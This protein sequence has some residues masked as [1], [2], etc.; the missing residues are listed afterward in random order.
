MGFCIF[1]FTIVMTV[2][3]KMRGPLLHEDDRRLAQEERRARNKAWAIGMRQPPRGCSYQ[4]WHRACRDTR[5]CLKVHTPEPS[6]ENP[7]EAA[8]VYLMID[9]DKKIKVGHSYNLPKRICN[10]QH[11]PIGGMPPIRLVKAIAHERAHK[12]EG[13]AHKLLKQK[14][15]WNGCEWFLITPSFA[16][17]VLNEAIRQVEAG[18]RM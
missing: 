14:G 1:V 11:Q 10:L 17:R 12:I 9:A 15:L 4:E 7:W 5:R 3:D 6:G 18:R 8:I 16:S 2:V 13:R